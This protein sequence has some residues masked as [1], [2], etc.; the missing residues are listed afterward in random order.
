MRINKQ[1]IF[2]IFT[3]LLW[4]VIGAACITLLVSAAYSKDLKHCSGV[5][6]EITGVSN[7]YFIDKDDVYTILKQNGGDSTLKKPIASINLKKIEK[8][9]EKDVWIKNAEL[10]FDNNNVLRIS[11]EERDPVARV[12]TVTGNSFYID[13]SCMMLP[14]SEKFSARLPLFTGFTSDAKILSKPDSLL[15]CDIKNV[16]MKIMA[17]DFLMAMIDQVDITVKRG[18]EMTPKIGKQVINFG[19]GSDADS[20]FARLKL[21][22]KNVITGAGWNRYNT[23]NLLYKDQVVATVK[24][25]EDVVADSLK[26][27]QIMK[28]IAEDAARKSADSTLSFAQDSEKNSTD[29][30]MILQ[31]IERDDR[32]GAAPNQ[33]L[34]PLTAAPVGT[35]SGTTTVLPGNLNAMP[36]SSPKTTVVIRKPIKKTDAKP[37]IKIN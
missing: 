32:G 9:L 16:S 28:M 20:K 5:E 31:S 33:N 29:S 27:L 8:Q 37:I 10:F 18:F 2:K 1:I 14:L 3:A 13:S 19:D 11:V 23:I 7:N 17:D 12:F 34:Q 15:L 21:F 6:I 24:G 36:A 26:T 30:T 4:L 35:V 22:Y 25:K